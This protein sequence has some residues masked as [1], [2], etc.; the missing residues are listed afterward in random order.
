MENQKEIWKDVPGYEEIY[1][2]SNLGNVKSIDHYCKGRVGSGKQTGRTLKQ[3]ICYKGY[4]RVRLYL[5]KKSFTTGAHRLV[6][7]AFIPNPLNLPQVNHINGIKADNKVENLEWCTNQYNQIH[8]VKN[9]LCNPNTC[10]KHHMSKLKN[11]DVLKVRELHRIGFKNSELAKDYDISQ[12]A[13][14]N[15]L[16]RKTYINI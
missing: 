10:E 3:H 5:N 12:T 13:M 8:A 2:V 7:I 9:G 1:Q 11:E 4:S 6:A 16:R 15:I 14:S